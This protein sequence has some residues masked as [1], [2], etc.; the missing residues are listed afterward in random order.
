MADALTAGVLLVEDIAKCI[1][2]ALSNFHPNHNLDRTRVIRTLCR[3]CRQ[4]YPDY[5]VVIFELGHVMSIKL[6]NLIYE[7]E[8]ELQDLIRKFRFKIL[9]FKE[10]GICILNG[11]K[12]IVDDSKWGIN[13]INIKLLIFD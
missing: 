8:H 10:G 11:R 1:G 4:A 6:D 5:N 12:A 7:Q 9:I 2:K 13:D 3:T